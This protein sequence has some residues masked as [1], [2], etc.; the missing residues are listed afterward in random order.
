MDEGVGDPLQHA[1]D[2]KVEHAFERGLIVVEAAAMGCV[3]AGDRPPPPEPCRD[4]AA[5][6]AA[7]GAMAVQ[8]VG[9]DPAE[10]FQHAPNRGEVA[11]RNAAAHREAGD[12]ELQACRGPRMR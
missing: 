11:E 2:P 6:G 12:A 8:H 9:G 1:L 4:Q 3:D 7:F 10:M 5:V